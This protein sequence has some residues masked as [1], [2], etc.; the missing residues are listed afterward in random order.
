MSSPTNPPSRIVLTGFSGAGKSA[1]GPLLAKHFGWKFLDTDEVVEK[2]AGK[3]ILDIFRD[4]GEDAF[5]DLEAEAIRK[6]CGD[7]KLV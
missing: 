4:D 7:D 2:R 5:R 3:R 6:A 1:V